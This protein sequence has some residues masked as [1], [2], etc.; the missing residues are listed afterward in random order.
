MGIEDLMENRIRGVSEA[1]DFLLSLNFSKRPGKALE[2]LGELIFLGTSTLLFLMK[3][4]MD[5]RVSRK[6]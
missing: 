1:L 4:S 3:T 6:E 5:F 2:K